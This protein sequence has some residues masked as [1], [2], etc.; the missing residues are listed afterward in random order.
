MCRPAFP[1]RL[2]NVPIHNYMATNKLYLS[3]YI[4]KR[5]CL[6]TV[7]LGCNFITADCDSWPYSC[8]PPSVDGCSYDYQAAVPTYLLYIVHKFT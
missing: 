4:N 2:L 8:S 6:L 3:L 7:G 5:I 1:P